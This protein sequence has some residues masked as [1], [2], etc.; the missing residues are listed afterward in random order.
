MK[1]EGLLGKFFIK[2]EEYWYTVFRVII[3][4]VFLL[5]GL[6]KFG[7]FGKA[8]SS[9]MSLMGVAGIIEIT[10]GIL[11]ALGLLTRLVALIGAIEMIT[12]WFIVHA[13]HG[14]NPLLNYGEAAVLFFVIFL[15]LLVHGGG[16]YTIEHT[17]RKKEIF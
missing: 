7:V 13:P 8:S 11:I 15:V 14:W 1:G 16:K 2:G 6:S 5:H 9:I 10:G 4:I 12:A 3:G 17:I